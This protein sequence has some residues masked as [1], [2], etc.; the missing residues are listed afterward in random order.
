MPNSSSLARRAN[1]KDHIRVP[2]CE[3]C[4][5]SKLAC[6]H[7]RPTCSRCINRQIVSRCV[8]RKNPFRRNKPITAIPDLPLCVF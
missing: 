5:L 6:D 4:R 2:S 1:G 8:Y 3:P 7:R